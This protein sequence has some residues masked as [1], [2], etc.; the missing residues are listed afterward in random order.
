MTK[1]CKECGTPIDPARVSAI[2]RGGSYEYNGPWLC[3][4]HASTPPVAA[5]PVIK[6]KTEYA[7]LEFMSQEAA[8]ALHN[9]N[10]RSGQGPMAGIKKHRT[11]SIAKNKNK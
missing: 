7:E 9:A 1:Y 3:I 2:T 10:A 4:D 6:G 11:A 5:Y 8:M